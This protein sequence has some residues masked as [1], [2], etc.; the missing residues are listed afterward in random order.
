M[1]R[2]GDPLPPFSL[3]SDTGEPLNLESLR[4]SRAVLFFYPKDNTSG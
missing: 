2:P 3:E 1:L 4:G